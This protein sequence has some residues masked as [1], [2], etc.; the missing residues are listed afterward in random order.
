MATAKDMLETYPR[1]FNVDAD[2]LASAI[3][4]LI[5]CGSTCTQCA[6][7]CLSEDDVAAMAKCI[8]LNL[9]C[10]D[11]CAT[12]SRVLGR[13]TEYDANVTRSLLEACVAACKSC[14]D[15]CQSHS[16]HMRHCAICAESCRRCESACQ[17]LLGAM[18]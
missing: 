10:A 4:A 5:E 8:R 7:A 2:T 16:E 14:G 17:E 13:Q 6:D 18:A 15:E 11:I 12:T 3:D 9:D 1:S